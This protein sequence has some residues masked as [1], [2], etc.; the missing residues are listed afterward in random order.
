MTKIEE[1]EWF[2]GILNDLKTKYKN[3]NSEVLAHLIAVCSYNKEAIE[4]QWVE[5][6][7]QSA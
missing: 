6:S 1:Y 4:K 3:H 7:R 2:I 5:K